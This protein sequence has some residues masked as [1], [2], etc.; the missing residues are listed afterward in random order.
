MQAVRIH[1]HG[2]PEVLQVESIPRPEPMDGEVVVQIKAAALNHLDLWVRRG[3]SG[4]PLPM[5]LGS[6]GSG[7]ISD[8]GENISQFA[9]GDAV[10][11][12]PLTYC[13]NCQFC[14]SGRENYCDNIGI[15]GESQDGTQCK[16]IAVPEKNVRLKPE[17]LS[18][19]EAAA[20]PLTV[21][22]AYTMLVRR[23]KIEPGE[24]VLVWGA[25]SGVGTMAIQIAKAKGC[26]V[27]ATGGS[28]QKRSH[29][30]TLGADLVLDH[31]GDNIVKSV[32]AFT[33][34]RGADVVFEHVGKATWETSMRLLAKGGRIVTCGATTGPKV[35]IDLR[36][37]FSKQQTILGSTMG[38][39]AAFDDCLSLVT[40]GT[41]KP[42]VDKVFALS[43]I[44]HAH[45]Y[46]EKGEQIGKVILL[47]E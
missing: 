1:S 14:R 21:Q 34:G 5:I 38:D 29:A 18:F 27:I 13:D 9:N 10:C 47:P 37:L 30:S 15:L 46:L 12:Q 23:A 41:I 45:E 19:Q 6:D 22:T 31:Y 40:K 28:E 43:D 33:D 11:I 20:F 3:I 42:I 7:V 39:V 2:G 17:N 8:V 4:V 32:K 25:G 36:H 44:K 35:G 26:Q 16:F 24:T